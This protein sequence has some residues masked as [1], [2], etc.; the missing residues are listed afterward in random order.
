MLCVVFI[1]FLLRSLLPLWC[2]TPRFVLG[3]ISICR[4]PNAGVFAWPFD[5][6]NPLS[7]ISSSILFLA[8]LPRC[9]GLTRQDEYVVTCATTSKSVKLAPSGVGTRV[10]PVYPVSVSVGRDSL[11]E[12][13]CWRNSQLRQGRR[14]RYRRAVYSTIRIY[15]WH[16]FVKGIWPQFLQESPPCSEVCGLVRDNIRSYLL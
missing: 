16:W 14:G 10:E 4:L 1:V 6:S 15:A 12:S 2:D 3:P 7:D 11:S 8:F 5:V 13:V 9:L